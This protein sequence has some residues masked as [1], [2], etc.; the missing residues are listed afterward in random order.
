LERA[1]LP[2]IYD[3]HTK[4]RDTFYSYARLPSK[5][6]YYDYND[7]VKDT[8]NF[9][10]RVSKFEAKKPMIIICD[11]GSSEQD[12]MAIKK[13]KIYGAKVI[14]I[15][16]HPLSKEIDKITDAH[17]NPHH[18]GST[19]DLSAGMLCAEIAKQLNNNVKEIEFVAALAG[20]GD[21]VESKELDQYLVM[22]KKLGYSLEN[23]IEIA[24]CLDYETFILGFMEGRDIVDDMLGKDKKKQE[25]LIKLIKPKVSKLR[26]EQLETN[27]KYGIVEENK[28]KIIIAKLDI[29]KVKQQGSY[30]PAGKTTGILQEYLVKKH[31]DKK[32]I[33]MG[34]GKDQINFRASKNTDDFDVNELIKILK[35]KLPYAQINGGGH[36]RA[37]SIS[38]IEA[39]KKEVLDIVKEYIDKVKK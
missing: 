15:D 23:M 27:I 20:I 31:I 7:A 35:N 19:Y 14:V 33:S 13:V 3:R 25:K 4:E 9:M 18:V 21:K 22:A 16:H 26:K 32:I 38:F 8:T 36:K 29:N 2:L 1:I 12:I 17:V 39:A 11:N 34:I 28:N 6:P 5:A 10:N 30:P 37:G 24:E